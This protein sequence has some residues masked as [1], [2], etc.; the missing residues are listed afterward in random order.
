MILSWGETLEQLCHYGCFWECFGKATVHKR[1]ADGVYL[2]AK[3]IAKDPINLIL[4][5][6]AF[7]ICLPQDI[8]TLCSAL[9]FNFVIRMC[10]WS[11]LP[12]MIPSKKKKL[13][14][15]Q[16]VSNRSVL[17]RKGALHKLPM[18]ELVNHSVT[19]SC[20]LIC[21]RCSKNF[22][23]LEWMCCWYWWEEQVEYCSIISVEILILA[24][25]AVFFFFAPLQLGFLLL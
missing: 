6:A 17:G 20:I 14:N 7:P 12:C 11:H 8:P 13:L 22:S 1:D 16:Y 2:D 19:L 25:S 23:Y 4:V 10:F 3:M 9:S 5:P 15:L 24:H 18:V 21:S